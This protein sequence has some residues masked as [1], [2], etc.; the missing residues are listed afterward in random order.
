M[1][2]WPIVAA[3]AAIV[4]LAFALR[5]VGEW[6]NVFQP[7]GVYFL[8]ADSYYH[9]RIADWMAANPGRVLTFDAYAA[10]P[11]GLPVGYRPML[12]GI[13]VGASYL[14]SWGMPEPAT[15][16]AVGAVVPPV[17][18]ALTIIPVYLLGR[19][20]FHSRL[21]GLVGAGLVAILPT[22][23]LH[24]SL[25]GFTDQHVL[26]TFWSVWIVLFLV[27]AVRRNWRWGLGAGLGQ[28]LLTF[29]WQG[30]MYLMAI[31]ALWCV[32]TFFYRHVKGQETSSVLASF[33]AYAGVAALLGIPFLIYYGAA[34]LEYASQLMLIG[35]PG[36]L[37]LYGRLFPKGRRG[38]VVLAGL[39]V[40]STAVVALIASQSTTLMAILLAV[41]QQLLAVFW[42]Y[43]STILEAQPLSFGAA[44]SLY[45]VAGLLAL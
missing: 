11:G 27:L 12:S 34:R 22:E 15:L 39:A 14:V 5:T 37:Y 23:F 40:G 8:G 21:V 30:S 16:D 3:V 24:R 1:R 32:A 28:A 29:S 33:A 35:V 17:V 18:G 36:I 25:L 26:E 31:A 45:G 2:Y 41:R 9:M 13:V 7:D 4:A 38:A 20:V 10:Y 43:R 42:G 19:Q 6:A 44:W